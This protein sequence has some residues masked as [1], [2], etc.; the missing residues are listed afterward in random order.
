[1]QSSPLSGSNAGPTCLVEGDESELDLGNGVEMGEVHA[2]MSTAAPP[3]R[4]SST[5]ESMGSTVFLGPGRDAWRPMADPERQGG[6]GSEGAE[7]QSG[8][9]V[10]FGE[11]QRHRMIA[12]L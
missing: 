6:E 5:T 9:V 10:G 11:R 7:H 8:E 2:A 1:M 12:R 3:I 4:R